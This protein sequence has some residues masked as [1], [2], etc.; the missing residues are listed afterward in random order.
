VYD[1]QKFLLTNILDSSEVHL[2]CVLQ[3]DTISSDDPNVKR[4]RDEGVVVIA[5]FDKQLQDILKWPKATYDRVFMNLRKKGLIQKFQDG[6]VDFWQI[7]Y[8]TQVS[9]YSWLFDPPSEEVQEMDLWGQIQA[10]VKRKKET[11]KKR[12]RPKFKK[13]REHISDGKRVLN[14]FRD[15][16]IEQ[17]NKEPYECESGNYTSKAYGMVANLLRWCSTP[18]KALQVVEMTFDN[19][20]TVQDR[21]DLKTIELA[22]LGTKEKVASLLAWVDFGVWQEAKQSHITRVNDRC[23]AED[24]EPTKRTRPSGSGTSQTG[25]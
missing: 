9:G 15:R 5:S 21:F 13:K 19:A 18:G 11:P 6:G 25:T 10:S 7:G 20:Q 14:Y 16:Y 24:W 8:Y 2:F 3:A 1:F 22:H 23:E 12:A 4:L 17:Y